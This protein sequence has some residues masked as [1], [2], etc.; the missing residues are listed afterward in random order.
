MKNAG[1][2]A[3]GAVRPIFLGMVA[4][5]AAW[6]L[7]FK[8]D[9]HVDLANL[10]MV[11]V[12][13]GCIATVWLPARASVLFSILSVLGFN[14]MFVPPR[15]RLSVDVPQDALLL[16]S[17]LM[18][19]LIVAA[20]MAVQRSTSNRSQEHAR[21]ADQLRV[22]GETLRDAPDPL[23]HSG[24]LLTALGDL[25]SGNVK[26]LIVK[27]EVPKEN[28]A[29]SALILG[30][31]A[32]DQLEALW[33]CLRS[34]TALGSASTHYSG[35]AG[36]YLPMRGR[37]V[38]LGAAFLGPHARGSA[39]A[40]LHSQA[41][42]LCDQ[43]GLA[44][45]RALTARAAIQARDQAQVQN[46]RTAMLAAISHDYRT[47]LA[48]IMGA[49][50]SLVDQG[51]R[52][53]P[54]QR[55]RLALTIIEETTQLSR[56]TDNMLQL[57]RLYAPGMRLLLDWE[58][59]E[60]VIATVLQ[61]ARGHDPHQR[62]RASLDPRLPLVRCDALLLTQM[63]DNLVDNA[64]KYSEP[65]TLVEMDVRRQEGSIVF[66]VSD[67]GQGVHPD[68]QEIMFDAFQRGKAGTDLRA[69]AARSGQR[70]AGVG[71]AVCR[72]IA[73]LHDG[74]LR[75]LPRAGGG[76]IFEFSLPEATPP[77]GAEEAAAGA[78]P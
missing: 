7:M 4:W 38:T 35:L 72:A 58:S 73:R 17:M 36:W 23:V 39:D 22:F 60:E 48:T 59:A 62:V 21:E 42:A 51:S 56:L 78:S 2:P 19:T 76:S 8:L 69:G 20:L 15:N 66:R 40:T 32:P 63:L 33:H 5:A 10:A 75:F 45:Q 26:A 34:G 50:S 67:R 43:F 46:V 16:G 64:L 74:K 49:A 47:P 1:A 6:A 12:L 13:G 55:E 37:G 31:P 14:W 3:S 53:H 25:T 11:L 18:V 61:R 77:S 68:Y 57:A 54:G 41:Q 29:D 27:A 44:M 70:G 24:K 9:P 71:L 28:D 30:E 65:P 52:L